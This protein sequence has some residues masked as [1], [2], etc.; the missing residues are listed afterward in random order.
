MADFLFRCH[1]DY[2]GALQ[3]LAVARPGLPNNPPFLILS[4]YINRRRNNWVEAERD[5]SDAVALDPRNPN[6][7]NLLA[8]TY[9]LQRRHLLASQVYDRVLAAGERTPIVFFRRDS[10]IFNGTGNSTELRKVLSENP[11]MDI[12]GGQTPIRV[13]L[14]LVEGNFA[15]A[16]RV[17]AASPRKD[18]Q[19][20]D[21]SFYYSKAWFEAMIA[22]A[23][24]DSA[25]AAEA[26]SIARAILEQRLAVKPEDAR[27]IAV[28]AQVDANLGRKELAIQEAQHAVELMPVSKDIYDGAL[29]LEG[30][31]QVYTWSNE[32]DRAIE[33]LQ[34]L[35]AMPGYTNYARL[36]LHPM[37]NPLRGDPRFEKIV[38]SLAPKDGSHTNK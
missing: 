8:D 9:N 5:F 19:D 35:V 23:K 25:R 28:L 10:A 16:E 12:G 31:A 29:V 6:A 13:F 27:T 7:Y 3:E 14:A 38:A 4:G 1:R 34:K 33:L 36:K 26:F 24:G 11:D 30:L 2:D 32:S 17:L 18:F 37:W 21:Y 15:E 22:R 20:I